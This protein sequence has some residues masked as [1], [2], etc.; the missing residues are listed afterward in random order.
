MAW[1]RVG[2]W[3]YFCDRLRTRAASAR[4]TLARAFPTAHLYC[5]LSDISEH[6]L[7]KNEKHIY[8][9]ISTG[10]VNLRVHR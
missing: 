6:L 3:L 4:E 8:P 10:N 7:Y 1:W 2:L 5:I 9:H